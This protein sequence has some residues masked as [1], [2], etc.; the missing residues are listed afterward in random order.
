MFQGPKSL[1][2]TGTGA[3]PVKRE[4]LKFAVGCGLTEMMNKDY[5]RVGVFTSMP[6]LT[7][8]NSQSG[9]AC[10]GHR[11]PFLISSKRQERGTWGSQRRAPT[12]L[13]VLP[14]TIAQKRK[15][16]QLSSFPKETKLVSPRVWNGP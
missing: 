15:W 8:R 7:Y 14:V 16:S 1:L 3:S 6:S 2:V 5:C 13:F 9:H 12:G 11:A 4:Q 10:E